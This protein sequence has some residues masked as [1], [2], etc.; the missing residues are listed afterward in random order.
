MRKQ[1]TGLPL[2]P[3]LGRSPVP[4]LLIFLPIPQAPEAPSIVPSIAS[5]KGGHPGPNWKASFA[6]N[7]PASKVSKTFVPVRVHTARTPIR[8]A[9]A[10]SVPGP[11][12]RGSTL[13]RSCWELG[14]CSLLGLSQDA[15]PRGGAGMEEAPS[16]ADSSA[17]RPLLVAVW[18]HSSLSLIWSPPF[19]KR[20]SF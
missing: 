13:R 11:A 1:I 12:R 3:V 19:H 17:P 9:G 16:Q 18:L 2:W 14:P 15:H 7:L 6:E 5:L 4:F 20:L 10:C 8:P